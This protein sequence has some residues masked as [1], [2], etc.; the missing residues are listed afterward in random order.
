MCDSLA[1]V[2]VSL[3][4]ESDISYF[5]LRSIDIHVNMQRQLLRLGA[6][7]R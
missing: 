4:I 3:F 7:I 1:A 6:Y 5:N 2:T